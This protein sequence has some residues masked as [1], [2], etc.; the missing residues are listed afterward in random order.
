MNKA[1]VQ[2]IHK[3]VT[4]DWNSSWSSIWLEGVLKKIITRL[5]TKLYYTA[6]CKQQTLIRIFFKML[7]L[8]IPY[9]TKHFYLVSKDFSRKMVEKSLFAFKLSF[10]VQTLYITNVCTV[11]SCITKICSSQQA[12]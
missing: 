8:Y 1:I 2:F 9:L 3:K 7:F 4:M 5:Y 6:M 12:P 10:W 11:I